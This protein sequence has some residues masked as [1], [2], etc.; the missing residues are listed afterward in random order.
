[1]H[2]NLHP[3]RYVADNHCFD[4]RRE[5]AHP[6]RLNADVVGH[7]DEVGGSEFDRTDVHDCATIVRLVTPACE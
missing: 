1:M 3:I 6:Y 7:V 2:T 4:P 5:Q